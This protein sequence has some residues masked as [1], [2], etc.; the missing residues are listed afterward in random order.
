MWCYWQVAV[1]ILNGEEV[2]S[3]VSIYVLLTELCN[4]S[5]ARLE[6]YQMHKTG[7][8]LEKVHFLHP[9]TLFNIFFWLSLWSF[10]T[11]QNAFCITIY[12]DASES[13]CNKFTLFCFSFLVNL[14]IKALLILIDHI[15]ILTWY[16][17]RILSNHL[18]QRLPFLFSFLSKLP[19][20]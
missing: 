1:L 18:W 20:N 8:S 15:F 6:C 14:L 4:L 7:Q 3:A 17:A 19:R 13:I 12:S 10:L 9:I 16:H 5:L 2:V 11:C